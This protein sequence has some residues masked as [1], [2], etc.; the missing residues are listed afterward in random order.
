MSRA[1][2]NIPLP[3][4]PEASATSFLSGG[5][6]PHTLQEHFLSSHPHNAVSTR[7]RGERVADMTALVY[8]LDG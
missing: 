5:Y 1:G 6:N 2:L 7:G 3:K 4:A 8:S